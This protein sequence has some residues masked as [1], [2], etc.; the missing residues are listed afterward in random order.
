MDSR[1]TTGR[2]HLAWQLVLL[3]A[4]LAIGVLGLVGK[5]IGLF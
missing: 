3:L 1:D 5:L 4:I 2:G